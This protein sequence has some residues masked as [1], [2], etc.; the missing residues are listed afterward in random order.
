[1]LQNNRSNKEQC[2]QGAKW[3]KPAIMKHYK[4][5]DSHFGKKKRKEGRE[6]ERERGGRKGRK[7]ISEA[8]EEGMEGRENKAKIK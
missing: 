5:I 6:E 2:R 4:Q 1:M 7:K 3:D 8:K